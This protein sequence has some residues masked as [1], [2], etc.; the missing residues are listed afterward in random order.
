MN[1]STSIRNRF[2]P[3]VIFLAAVF[4]IA[5][6]GMAANDAEPHKQPKSAEATKTKTKEVKF[7]ELSLKV[8]E[9]WQE[10]GN[11]SKFKKLEFAIPPVK[12]DS[13]SA[14]LYVSYGSLAGRNEQ[15]KPS[16]SGWHKSFEPEGRKS[17]LTEG[18]WSKGKYYIIDITG[19]YN[20]QVGP[21]A[22]PTRAL[23]DARVLTAILAK[24]KEGGD[25]LLILS[26]PRKTV[27]SA[28]SAFR[29][30]FGADAKKE[31]ELKVEE[32]SK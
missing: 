25:Y 28:A 7:D 1:L 26:G 18:A 14:E 30:S 32:G 5:A 4:G 19:T 29:D 24:D 21:A 10:Q 27:T 2:L 31:K 9:S 17:K 23:P 13:E 8:P 3:A 6:V 12:G 20:K 11:T 15:A 16:M 22:E